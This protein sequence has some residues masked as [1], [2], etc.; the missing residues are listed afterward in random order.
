[1][2]GE[3]RPLPRGSLRR[4]DR[5]RA[6]HR[7]GRRRHHRRRLRR[8]AR[9]R[10]AA[11]RPASTTSASSRRAATS[12]APG[13]GTATR[14][15]CA[16]SSPTSTCRCSKRSATSRRRSTRTRPRSSSTAGRSAS[17]STSTTTR[18]FQTEVTELALGRRDR[19]AGSCTPTAATRMRARF[20]VHGERAA[21]PAEAA[22]AS[23]ASTT[24]RATPSTPAA[25]TTAT[26]AATATGTS[27]AC[28]DKRVGIIG[29]GATAVQAIPHLGEAAEHLYVFQ[30]TPSSIDVRGNRPTDPE[31]ASLARAGL[32]AAPDGQL[33]H[34]GVAA[35]SQD[36]DL[37]NDGWTDIIGKLLL[38]DPAAARPAS[39]PPRASRRT[40]EMAD[41]EKMEQIRARVD[42][43]RRGSRRPPRR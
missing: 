40:M 3:L 11:R 31:W 25:G 37:V 20:V 9:R 13:T 19:A 42:D 30:R 43:D 41:F 26:P 36:E 22:R 8:A 6:A 7:R 18:C 38:H 24:S 12:A 27:P 10:A 32:A 21:A 39:S 15:R 33:Q 16:T 29:T 14:A 17:T 35:A 23:P 5:A 28:A 4:A 2:A 1:M 34:P